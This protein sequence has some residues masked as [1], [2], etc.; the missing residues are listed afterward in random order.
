MDA[1]ILNSGKLLFYFNNWK[2]SA[3]LYQIINLYEGPQAKYIS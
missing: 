3:R 2:Q 1:K